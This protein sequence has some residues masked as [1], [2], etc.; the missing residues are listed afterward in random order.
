LHDA[1]FGIQ[2]NVGGLYHIK[3]ISYF[4][5]AGGNYGFIN[6]QKNSRNGNNDTGAL[7]FRIGLL[8]DLD[9]KKNN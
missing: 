9:S 5:E 4:I 7:I 2:G 1:N 8:Y 3:S 6:L